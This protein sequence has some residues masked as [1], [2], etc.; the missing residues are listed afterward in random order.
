[1]F[2]VVSFLY[3]KP[4]LPVRLTYNHWTTHDSVCVPHCCFI[5]N[6]VLYAFFLASL[7]ILSISLDCW[8]YSLKLHGSPNLQLIHDSEQ[9][10]TIFFCYRCN[11]NCSTAVNSWC[12]STRYTYLHSQHI[13]AMHATSIDDQRYIHRARS[14]PYRIDRSIYYFHVTLRVVQAN[15]YTALV[16]RDVVICCVFS[17]N[18]R[19]VYVLWLNWQSK[20]HQVNQTPQRDNASPS[21]KQRI[22]IAR[23]N[24]F[25]F[26]FLYFLKP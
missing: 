14:L 18:E 16:A 13:L 9:K 23:N 20:L 8:T 7:P 11:W 3:L 6:I 21:Q 25:L 1:M 17:Q 26:F 22:E 5:F 4:F 10:K 24:F 2:S 19:W 12:S 15:L